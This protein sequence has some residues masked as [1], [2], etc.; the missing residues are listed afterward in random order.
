MQ[1]SGTDPDFDV[2]READLSTFLARDLATNG[3]Y[4]PL[5]DN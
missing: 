5:R 3:N 2:R 1:M 4:D